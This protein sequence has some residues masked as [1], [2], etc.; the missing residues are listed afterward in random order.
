MSRQE[1]I[2][3]AIFWGAVFGLLS[4]IMVLYEPEASI[5]D[6]WVWG[7]LLTQTLLGFLIGYVQWEK[8]WWYRGMAMGA[9]Q[10]DTRSDLPY[11][12]I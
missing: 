8:P 10:P 5:T 4:R 2:K 6:T 12:W 7:M 1:R 9:G 11:F 3:K